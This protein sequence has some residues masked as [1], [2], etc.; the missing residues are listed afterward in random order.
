M[1]LSA[2]EL[3]EAA[4][5]LPPAQRRELARR[6]LES[7]EVVDESIDEK[8]GDEIASRVEDI[9]SGKVKTIPHEQVKAELAAR[10]AERQA[11]EK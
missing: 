9:V 6:L 10:R 11:R 7:A 3:F 1:V 4:L 5:D 8:W 2:D